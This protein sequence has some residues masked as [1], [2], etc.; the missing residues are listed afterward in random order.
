LPVRPVY[1]KVSWRS[2][3]VATVVK[4][5]NKKHWGCCCFSTCT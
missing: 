1:A 2:P 3:S 5:V 4:I